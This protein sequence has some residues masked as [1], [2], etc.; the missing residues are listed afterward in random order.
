MGLRI[1]SRTL[2]KGQGEINEGS[3]KAGNGVTNAPMGVI[4]VRTR[5][6]AIKSPSRLAFHRWSACLWVRALKGPE[7]TL[8]PKP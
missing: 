2:L 5:V 3:E 1:I 8:N 4:L 6:S 7:V